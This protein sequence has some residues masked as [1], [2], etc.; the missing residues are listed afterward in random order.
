[1]YRQCAAVVM[2]LWVCVC[3]PLHMHK[4]FRGLADELYSPPLSRRVHVCYIYT[5]RY[6]YHNQ[7]SEVRNNLQESET[8]LRRLEELDFMNGP[9]YVYYTVVR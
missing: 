5:Y 1:M 7:H 3:I 6:I 2:P 8:N 9:V 4:G